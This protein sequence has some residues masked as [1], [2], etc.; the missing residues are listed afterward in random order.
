MKNVK[1]WEQLKNV[2]NEFVPWFA[3]VTIIFGAILFKLPEIAILFAI[4]LFI[5]S[6]TIIVNVISDDLE[7]I[8][9]IYILYMIVF[10]LEFL[11]IL[12]FLM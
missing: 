11:K 12:S 1:M 5:L 2:L 3:I 8:V 4:T 10:T 6:K 7:N 9:W